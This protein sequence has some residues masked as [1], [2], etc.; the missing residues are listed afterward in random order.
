MLAPGQRHFLLLFVHSCMLST[1]FNNG[2]RFRF[3]KRGALLFYY[4]VV[5][6]AAVRP[7]SGQQLFHPGPVRE[8]LLFGAASVSVVFM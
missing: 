3:S 2:H 6:G 1:T 7:V 8:E 5:K 4:P